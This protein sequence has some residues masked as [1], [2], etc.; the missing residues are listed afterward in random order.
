MG[1]WAAQKA[2]FTVGDSGA[3]SVS[4]AQSQTFLKVTQFGVQDREGSHSF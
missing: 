3:Q 1:V 2:G 4:R